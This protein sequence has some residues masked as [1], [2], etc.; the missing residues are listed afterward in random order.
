M[1]RM[2]SNET[3]SGTS[4]LNDNDFV[5]CAFKNC[6]FAGQDLSKFNFESCEFIGCDDHVQNGKHSVFRSCFQ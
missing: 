4:I 1:H 6:S 3:I 5:N 2:T